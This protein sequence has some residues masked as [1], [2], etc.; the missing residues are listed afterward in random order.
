MNCA[1]LYTLQS[2]MAALVD[3]NGTKMVSYTYDA[4]GKPISKAGTLA[5]TLG[6]IQ[7]FRYRG[8][9]YD[10]EMGLYYL[11]SRYYNPNWG[12]FVNED[13]VVEAGTG[14]ISANVY[15]YCQN[16]PA[17]RVDETGT[18]SLAAPVWQFVQQNGAYI[19]TIDGPL[20]FCD[21]AIIGVVAVGAFLSIADI[22]IGLF[23]HSTSSAVTVA[24]LSEKIDWGSGNTNHIRNGSKNHGGHDW[25]PF[26]IG[27]NDP[28][29]WEKLLPLLKTVADQGQQWQNSN[30]T[31]PIPDVEYYIYYFE[32]YGHSI[33]L[34]LFNQGTHYS[35][36]D[37]FPYP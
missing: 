31:K 18:E 19:S 34:K 10:E 7:P 20:P 12:R 29:W 5:S 23:S 28:K 33:V 27:P 6:T 36:S 25:S 24:A 37:A 16:N 35:I 30:S 2:D 9:V 17:N 4:W 22:G 26:G 21:V 3:S 32:E 15:M 8:Y 11:R 14:Y 13:S 1:N